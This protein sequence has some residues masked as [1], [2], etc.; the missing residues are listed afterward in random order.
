MSQEAKPAPLKRGLFVISP[1]RC[2]SGIRRTF[3]LRS[4]NPECARMKRGGGAFSQGPPFGFPRGARGAVVSTRHWAAH[5]RNPVTTDLVDF[6]REAWRATTQ[7]NASRCRC[8]EILRQPRDLVASESRTPPCKRGFAFGAAAPAK[9][10]SA[11]RI[12]QAARR[13]LTVCIGTPVVRRAADRARSTNLVPSFW[14]LMA[15]STRR[16]HPP[17]QCNGAGGRRPGTSAD[18]ARSRTWR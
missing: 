2:L 18:R 13:Q 12:D 6:V 9:R 14:P 7:G 11:L 16:R 4:S 1:T 8:I 17:G 3:F 10:S 5:L 15:P